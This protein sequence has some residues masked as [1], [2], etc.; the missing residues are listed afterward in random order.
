LDSSSA[1][2]ACNNNTNI[3][4]SSFHY[5]HYTSWYLGIELM[6]GATLASMYM[7]V[8][9]I[10]IGFGLSGGLDTLCSQA[11][12]A[13]DKQQVGRWFQRYFLIL[14]LLLVPVS[15]LNWFSKTILV[16]ILRQPP[17]IS[18]YA[19]RYCRSAIIVIPALW[20]YELLKKLFITQGAVLQMILPAIITNITNIGF[21]LFVLRCTNYGLEGLAFA[22]SLASLSSPCVLLIYSKYTKSFELVWPSDGWSKEIFF[23]WKT[24]LSFGL[25]CLFQMCLEW[26]AFE[27]QAAL[28]GL[29]PN[30]NITLGAHQILFNVTG[31]TYMW[32]SGIGTAISVYLANLLGAGRA[33]QAYKSAMIGLVLAGFVGLL[34]CALLFSLMKILPS[35][36]V[37]DAQIIIETEKVFPVL[38]SYQLV[39]SLE[40]AFAAIFRGCGYQILCASYSFIA[41]YVIGLPLSVLLG[42]VVRLG[43]LGVWLGP[44]VALLLH[45]FASFFTLKLFNFEKLSEEAIE[46]VTAES[47][48]NCISNSIQE[49]G[50]PL[51]VNLDE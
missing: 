43:L 8:F 3:R 42:F 38:A 22:R 30:N 39:D 18:D 28:S 14:L 50:R 33:K 7:N 25:P 46:R 31:F 27:L 17:I 11:N 49:D 47:L 13:G 10:S 6:E 19:Q 12:G 29:L 1:K 51:L 21:S 44:A 24:A 45:S 48:Q 41:F 37:R 32:Y 26:W 15:I 9:G 4:I 36:F 20:F 23:S 2:L 34:F 16:Y 40:C 35:F 5:H